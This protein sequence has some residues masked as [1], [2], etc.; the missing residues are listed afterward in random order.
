V[1]F[2][3]PQMMLVGLARFELPSQTIRLC[4]GG[5]VYFEG[6]KY[7]SAD[8]DFGA[9][10]SVSTLEEMTGDE[11]PGAT[12]TFLPASTAA[13]ATLSQPQFQGSPMTFWI[14]RVDQQTG[15]VLDAE[16]VGDLELD[17]TTLRASKGER[18]LDIGMI[19]VA[20]R[21]FNFNEGNVMSP[22]FHTSI[23]PGELGFNNATGATLTKAWGVQAPPRGSTTGSPSGT[24]GTS[25]WAEYMIGL[26]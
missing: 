11:A 16:M 7:I 1:S 5:F 20:E 18:L 6:E 8:P 13:A 9:I 15:A 17:T 14:A 2:D 3:A 24:S 4:D 22:R 10:Q 23:W 12:I 21:L 26:M 19:S 25:A